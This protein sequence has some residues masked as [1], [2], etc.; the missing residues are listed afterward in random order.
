MRSI[1]LASSSPYR[2]QLLKRLGLPFQ[3]L[4][5]EVDETARSTET[6]AALA[7]RLAC[8][9][10][11]ALAGTHPDSLI[12][13]SDQVACLNGQAMGKP[14]THTNALLQLKAAQGEWVD[15]H[16]GVCVYDS[17]TG[18]EYSK[19]ATYRVKFKS[20]TEKQLDTYL[21]LEKP[22]DCAGSFKSEGLGIT[23]FEQMEGADPTGLIGLPLITLTSL[24]TLAGIDPLS[25]KPSK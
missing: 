9:K 21:T 12:I 20:L 8:D 23:L 2:A 14:G 16:T 5:P 24:L 15:F 11:C 3:A 10:A 4:S 17:K 18:Q 25:P 13:G 1:I 7:Q 22:Y 19:L 6:P